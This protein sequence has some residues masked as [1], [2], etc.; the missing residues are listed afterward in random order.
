MIRALSELP[1]YDLV[2]AGSGPYREELERYAREESYGD[3]VDFL[4]YVSDDRL[5]R[6]Y[7]GASVYVTLSEFEAY[8]MTVAEALAAGTPC[9]VRK[10]GALSDWAD[11]P[12]VEGVDSMSPG[13]VSEA[14][15]KSLSRHPN[16]NVTSWSMVTDQLAALLLDHTEGNRN[17]YRG[18]TASHS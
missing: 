17:K 18:N 11:N 3:R 6:L 2:I 16:G 5:P 15:D 10:E 12:A 9:V 1:E 7:T 14:I 4:G 8:G 13:S